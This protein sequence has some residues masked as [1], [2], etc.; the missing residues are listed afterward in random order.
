MP[1]KRK[2]LVTNALPYANGQ[3]HLGHMVGYIQADIWVRL[4][5][6]QGHDCLYV[7]GSDCHGTPIMISA[8]KMGISPET[9]IEKI[10][11]DHVKDFS[12]FAVDFDNYYG[13]HSEE[14]HEIVDMIFK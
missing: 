12:D 5:K 9:M 6:M 10:S 13:T 1:A 2:I 3:I 4:Q 11:A 14:N 7:C 8:E